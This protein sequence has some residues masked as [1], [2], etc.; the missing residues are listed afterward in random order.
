[1]EYAVIHARIVE[2]GASFAAER[3]TR[4]RRT[5]LDPLDFAKLR[6][7]GYPLVAVPA[8]HGGAFGNRATA[9]R[10]L[11]RI[12]RTLA[13]GDSSVALVCAMHPAVLSLWLSFP[14][15]PT[16]HD[17]HWQEQRDMLFASAREGAFVGT[18]TSEPGSGGDIALTRAVARKS[19]GGYLLV[20]QKHFGSGSGITSLMVTTAIP[21]GEQEADWFLIDLRGVPWD[22][23]HGVKL[24][25]P[26]DGH[27][28]VATQSH[29]LNFSGFPALR[30]A[31]P[32]QRQMLNAAAVPLIGCLFAS[33]ATGIVDAAMA[34]AA[35][36]IR[37]ASAAQRPFSQVEW[38]RAEIDA[39]LVQQALEGMIRAVETE[40]PAEREI[41]K[42][43]L[44]IAELAESC[45]QRLCRIVGGGTYARRSP[46]G[47][48]FEDI[49]AL[50]FLRPPW[51]LAFDQLISSASV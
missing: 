11:C 49:R 34:L 28:M 15:A 6:Q 48:L 13:Q 2:L 45:L 33:V 24:I 5:E 31:W 51:S 32:G 22:G 21:E 10:P 14:H 30:C 16:E 44:A 17:A 40:R 20:G 18:I 27:G 43:K 37:D 29:S 50:G 47:C 23:S 8:E 1:M 7:A 4:Q 25:A 41:L 39:W 9:V 26:W 38:A 36:Q 46:I 35:G 19:D 12:L 42:G 3:P